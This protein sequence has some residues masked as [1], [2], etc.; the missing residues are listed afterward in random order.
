MLLQVVKC[1]H[2][3]K[4]TTHRFILR[5]PGLLAAGPFSNP[6]LMKLPLLECQLF[7]SLVPPTLG[8][9]AAAAAG[10]AQEVPI[11]TAQNGAYTSENQAGVEHSR[12]LVSIRYFF[13]V[14]TLCSS[15]G[16]RLQIKNCSRVWEI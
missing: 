8:P 14:V 6:T 11:P 9:A 5:F 4:N 7:P 1:T 2:D 3:Q 13:V 16:R 15:F 12:L 10:T